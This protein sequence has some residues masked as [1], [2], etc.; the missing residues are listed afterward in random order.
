MLSILPGSVSKALI[1]RKNP[2]DSFPGAF[3]SKLRPGPRPR[4]SA[5]VSTSLRL[6]PGCPVQRVGDVTAIAV[7]V[8]GGDEVWV[9]VDAVLV[10]VEPVELL[11]R[12]D[13]DADGGLEYS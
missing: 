10:D 4:P 9:A 11:V 5:V 8:V 1:M 6:S 3:R 7:L 12:L 13:P 2:E